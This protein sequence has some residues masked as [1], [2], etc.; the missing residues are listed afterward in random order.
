[1]VSNWILLYLIE[2]RTEPAKEST[3]Q[4]SCM[5]P[6]CAP[7]SPRRPVTLSELIFL[8]L[9]LEYAYPTTGC[10]L[11]LKAV[12]IGTCTADVRCMPCVG[13]VGPSATSPGRRARST[14]AEPQSKPIDE[15]CRELIRP[16]AVINPA[17]SP[18]ASY[19]ASTATTPDTGLCSF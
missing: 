7:Q 1:V 5:G 2:Y 16:D 10:W 6:L 3:R 14:R 8:V 11:R 4:Y 13:C 19:R 9:G 17:Q 18:L 15:L 12:L